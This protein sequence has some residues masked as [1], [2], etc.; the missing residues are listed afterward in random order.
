[1]ARVLKVRNFSALPNAFAA[2]VRVVLLC[3]AM[4][5]AAHAT[6]PKQVQYRTN[7]WS[8]GI[9]QS[10]TDAAC[11]YA[12]GYLKRL[13][14]E[15]PYVIGTCDTTKFIVRKSDSQTYSSQTQML[16]SAPQCPANSTSVTDGCQC[17]TGFVEQNGT[18]C[19]DQNTAC[20]SKAGKQSVINMTIAWQRTPT[21]GYAEWFNPTKIPV[22]QVVSMCSGGCKVDIDIYSSEN[23]DL[24]LG[25]GYV[26]QQPNAQGMYRRSMDFLATGGGTAC[27]PTAADA[28]VN[29]NTAN[30]PKCPGAVGEF[31]GKKVCVGTADNPLRGDMPNPELMKGDASVGNPAAGEKPATGEGSGAGGSGRTPQTGSGG[32]D[33]GPSG[34][35]GNSSVP[36]GTTGNGSSP[37]YTEKRD[38]EE[39]KNCG[40][41][42]QAK[43][44]IDE[45]GMPDGSDAFKGTGDAWNQAKTQQD[46]FLSGVTNKADKD[47]SWGIS[48]LSWLSH[49]QCQP[50]DLGTFTIM[51]RQKQ[52]RVDICAIEPY[53]IGVMN[54]LWIVGTFFITINMVFR[55]MT[56]TGD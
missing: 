41:P 27:T 21:T 2:L 39:Q 29:P 44:Q 56:K 46:T 38:G 25:G 43:C 14:P 50:W 3:L 40:S 51:G 10:S 1:M 4:C 19:V 45:T 36:A 48:S 33:G 16:T 42:G 34:A 53:V 23:Q 12:L 11:S 26:S 35:A 15:N 37:G 24:S 52:I 6:I 28:A 5:S 13:Y 8:D 7:D 17:K 20:S 30:D 9:W 22:G 47:T 31:N 54:F 32:S 49:E 55:V 18:T